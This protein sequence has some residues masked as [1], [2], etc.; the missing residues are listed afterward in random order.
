MTY[1]AAVGA[2]KRKHH[3]VWEHYLKAWG[4]NG[5][6]WC[7]RGETR[8]PASTENLAHR[9]DF[10][11]LKEMSAR[12]FEVVELL[13][14]RMGEHLQELARGW[15]P[16]FRIFH[17]IKRAY[18]ASG[19]SN[20]ELEDELDRSI[21]DLE[22]DLY[23]SVEDKAV[24]LLAALRERDGSVLKDDEQSVYFAW[25]IAMQYMRTPRIMRSASKIKEIPGFNAE[26]SWGLLRTILA[27]TLG[28]SLYAQRQATRLT[29]LEVP[30]GVELLTGDQPI[31]NT[32]A[33]RSHGDMPPE[34]LELYYPLTPTLAVLMAF[35]QGS[36]ASERR[37]MTVEGVGNYN[38]MIA[39]MADEQ[40][41]ARSENALLAL[42][43]QGS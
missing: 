20:R 41:Y 32:R 18:E 28:W 43:F 39:A 30:R 37:E 38:R 17:E 8:F 24:P 19:Q 31:V 4:V 34:D 21:N 40:I 7:Q 36:F 5:K 29:F 3:F 25:F 22:E 15:L 9:R 33:G 13:I 2:K 14:S 27:T 42:S 6:V 12:D 1:A 10:Y 35:D 26:A 23:A 11:R 16:H